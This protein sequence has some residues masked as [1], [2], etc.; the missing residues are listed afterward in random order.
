MLE[1]MIERTLLAS[2]WLMAPVYLGLSLALPG[3]GIKFFQ[4]ITP[5]FSDVL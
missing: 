4:E 5:M 2:R 3:L 1:R